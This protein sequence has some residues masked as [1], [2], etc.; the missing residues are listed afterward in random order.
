MGKLREYLVP[1]R[2]ENI[3]DK[4]KDKPLTPIQSKGYGGSGLKSVDNSF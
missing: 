1:N 2:L 4:L 3:K